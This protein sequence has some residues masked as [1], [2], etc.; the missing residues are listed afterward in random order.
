MPFYPTAKQRQIVWQLW[1]SLSHTKK[2]MLQAVCGAGKTEIATLIIASYL[3]RG[4]VVGWA[5]ARRDV[6]VELQERLQAYFPKTT[7]LGLYQDSPDLGRKG[8]LIVL[9][10]AR[11]SAFY[12]SFD[13]LVIDENDAYPFSVSAFQQA[14]AA[15]SVIKNAK[16]LYIS[17]TVEQKDVKDY[18]AIISLS[19]RF[20]EREL[21][22]IE[23]VEQRH[24]MYREH[25]DFFKKI[26]GFI[27]KGQPIFIYVK[28]K[29]KGLDVLKVLIRYWDGCVENVSSNDQ[30]RTEILNRVRSGQTQ[31]LITTT[32]L[33]R[34][35]TFKNLQVIVLD[36]DADIFNAAT[37][38]QIAGRVGRSIE[39]IEG[40]IY[41]YYGSGITYAMRRAKKYHN[42]ANKGEVI[43]L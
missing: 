8:Q 36:A 26:A 41:F 27:K 39:S 37:L 15:M 28:S 18:D 4:G 35:V 43:F 16:T 19:R 14:T 7:V 9:T 2:V 23:F 40:E 22:Q 24:T 25:S 10:T 17:G 30:K 3:R 29:K 1:L 32:I 42:R 33:E 11:L 20:H 12:Q 31:I 6:V 34:G 13:F 5:I 38:V 21:P